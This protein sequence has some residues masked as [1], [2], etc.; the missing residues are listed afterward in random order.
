MDGH[1]VPLNVEEDLADLQ[2]LEI[3]RLHVDGSPENGLDAKY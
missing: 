3:G 1:L 2:A